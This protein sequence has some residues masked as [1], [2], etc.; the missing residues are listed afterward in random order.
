MEDNQLDKDMNQ[1]KGVP[2][3]IFENKS[4]LQK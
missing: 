1:G 3:V 4:K 2:L